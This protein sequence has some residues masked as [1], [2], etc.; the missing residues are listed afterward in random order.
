MHTRRQVILGLAA[1]VLAAP[2][3]ASAQP[4]SNRYRIGFLNSEKS[5]D[6]SQAK[7]LETLRA[8]LRELGYVEGTNLAI[9][10]RWAEGKYERLPGLAAE[11]VSL[12][13]S[14][15]VAAGTKAAI[16]VRKATTTIP[17]VMGSSGDAIALG[18]TTNLARPSANIT[19]WTMF[20]AEVAAKLL[21]LLKEFAPQIAKV[22]YVVNPADPVG[23]ALHSAARSLNLDLSVFEVRAPEELDR[24]FAQIARAGCDAVVVQ[25]DTMFDVN[26]RA[27]A[28]LALQYRLAAASAISDFAEA[29][30]LIS[31]GPDRLEGYR[32]AA[33]FVDKILKGARPADLPIEQA[34]NFDLAINVATAKA[35]GLTISPSLQLRARLVE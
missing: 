21:E 3:T 15:I 5:S 14:V 24:V 6:P 12:R 23:R 22:A 19:G 18:F 26:A 25:G 27:I 4:A 33:F 35:L 13:V 9:E 7:R 31:Y 29:G 1:A 34:T 30:G 28:R 8:S 16:A 11:L 20:G 10:T 2:G 32:R 17:I